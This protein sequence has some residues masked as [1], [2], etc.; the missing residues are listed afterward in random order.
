MDN[1][2]RY[3]YNNVVSNNSRKILYTAVGVAALFVAVISGTFA[4]FTAGATNNDTISGTIGSTNLQMTV[5]EL[6]Y[7]TAPSN[8]TNLI[9]FDTT[10]YSNL[11]TA[12]AN[13]N[14][15]GKTG[16]NKCSCVDRNGYA[17]CQVYRIAISVPANSPRI[18][19]TGTVK[20]VAG[21]ES[22]IPNL[23]YTILGP[24][25][26][27]TNDVSMDTLTTTAPYYSAK[28]T[29]GND[30]IFTGIDTQNTPKNGY[31]GA[32]PSAATYNYYLIVW[33]EDTGSSQNTTDYGTFN[34]TV[35]VQSA[36]GNITATFG[37]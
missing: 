36:S 1:Q 33:L 8:G 13:N 27:G 17:A 18:P 31:L 21:S 10:S 25:T 9:P 3:N 7:P 19:I 16:S 5:T 35:N 26:T 32:T 20:I 23:T 15:P 29:L 11:N 28:V 2:D 12:L 4:Y 6:T 24:Q 30:L 22:T 14:C 37:S 34:G